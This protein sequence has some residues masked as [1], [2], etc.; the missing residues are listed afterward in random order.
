MGCHSLLQGNFPTLGSNP[1]LQ[2]CRQNSYHLN[3]QG[4][5]FNKHILNYVTSQ[6]PEDTESGWKHHQHWLSL[7]LNSI[8]FRQLLFCPP[9]SSIVIERQYHSGIVVDTR[10]YTFVKTHVLY[11]TKSEPQCKLWISVHYNLSILV[12]KL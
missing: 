6:E 5:P 8:V 3:H 11:N 12:H 10:Y 9:A 1:G 4:S 7:A 2:H